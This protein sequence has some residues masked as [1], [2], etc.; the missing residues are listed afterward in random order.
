MFCSCLK[1]V[2][3]QAANNNRN[4]EISKKYFKLMFNL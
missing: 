1:H 2:V 4:L 3:K